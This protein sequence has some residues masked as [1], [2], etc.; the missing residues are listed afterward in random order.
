MELEVN[1]KTKEKVFSVSEYLD[2]LNNILKYHSVTIRGEV[3]EKLFKYPKYTFFNLLEKEAILQCFVYQDVIEKVGVALKGGMEIMIIGYPRIYKKTGALTFQV[4]K[5]ELVGEG[6]LKKQFEIL[7]KR[8]FTSGYFDDKYKKPVPK[9]PEKIGLITSTYG[10][11]AKK[12][13]LT[14]LT[15]FGFHITFYDSRVEGILALNEIIEAITWFNQN[16]PKIDALVL[17]RGGG[18]W[19]SLKPFNSEEIVKTIFASKIPVITGIGHENDETLADYVADLRASTPTHAASVLAKGWEK[20]DFFINGTEKTIPSLVNKIFHNIK[21]RINIF[22]NEFTSKVRREIDIQGGN[23]DNIIKNLNNSF[24]NYFRKFEVLQREFVK[25]ILRIKSSLKIKKEKVKDLLCFL[26]SNKRRW[27]KNQKTILKHQEE[28]LLISSPQFKLKQGYSITL[29][30]EG[31][32]IKEV[33]NLKI[34]QDIITKFYKGDV[35][36][37][38]RKIKK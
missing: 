17:T 34:S 15:D 11:G 20:A 36:S 10:K 16:L 30:K 2:F 29:D 4:E 5:I 14:N 19:E 8:L 6:I 33:D 25:N 3:G 13:F 21:E 23:L 9:F 1:N 18:N 22:E 26:I 32:I 12:D 28:K 35:L 38:I 24:Q 31:K 37:E 7:K 27:L